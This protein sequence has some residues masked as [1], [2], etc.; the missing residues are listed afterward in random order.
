MPGLLR[1]PRRL[2]SASLTI[3]LPPLGRG[4]VIL[5]DDPAIVIEDDDRRP[6]RG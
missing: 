1:P 2:S 3:L 6:A 5:G 4:R